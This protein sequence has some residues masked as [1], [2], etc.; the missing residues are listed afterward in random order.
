MS[1]S[2]D[3]QIATGGNDGSVKLWSRTG[4]PLKTLK[5]HKFN[6]YGVSWSSDGQTLATGG[7]DGRVNLWSHSGEAIATLNVGQGAVFSVSW[8]P[9]G[10][11]LA[12]GGYDGS[13]KL[14]SRTGEI[15][16]TFNLPQS[17]VSLGWSPNGQTLVAGGYDGSVKLL[18]IEDLDALLTRGCRWLNSYLIGSPAVLQT[19]TTCHTPERL[20]AA[21]PNLV[22]DSEALARSGS[23]DQAIQGFKTAQQW[24]SSLAFNPIT[25]ATALKLQGEAD[26]LLNDNHP[27]RALTKL[28]NAIALKPD[29]EVSANTW[30]QICWRGSLDGK[31]AL[32]LSAC[33]EAVTLSPDAGGIRD[34]R[35]LARALTGDKQGAIEDFQAYIQWL[36]RVNPKNAADRKVRRQR[37][38]SDLQAGKP[39]SAIF[40]QAVLE[41][42]KKEE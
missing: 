13:V 7:N 1:W 34:S 8:S 2:P 35:G 25:Q 33:N 21:A 37:W 24:N 23:L 4:E 6:V 38:I 22:A 12:T 30:N 28:R 5:A 31:A 11:T 18:P 41:Q 29:L 15:L 40:T 27:D 32:I 19:L 10:Q 42:L 14:W 9:D 16:R 26:Q 39:P 3:G 17:V 36:D 20:R